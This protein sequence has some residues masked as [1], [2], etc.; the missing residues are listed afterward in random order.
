M[1]PPPALTP[2]PTQSP[3]P[4]ETPDDK[5]ADKSSDKERAERTDGKKGVNGKL[6][7]GTP[8]EANAATGIEAPSAKDSVPVWAIIMAAVGALA[9]IAAGIVFFVRKRKRS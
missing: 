8:G 3:E 5:S 7:K 6:G 1:T 4:T 9:A 2:E